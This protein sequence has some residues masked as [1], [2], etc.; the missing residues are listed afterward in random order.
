VKRLL[1][2]SF[3]KDDRERELVSQ[4]L[5]ALYSDVLSSNAIGKGFERLFEIMD[6][7]VKDAPAAKTMAATFLAR[8]V[9]DEVLPPSFVAD[10][11]VCSL[12]GEIVDL[13]RLMLSQHHAGAKLERS[14]GPGDGR[15]VEEMKVTIDQVLQEYLLAKDV[16]EAKRCFAEL[17]CSLFYHEIVKRAVCNAMDSSAEDQASMSLLLKEL[18][19][20][21]LL[22]AQQAEKGFSRL[23]RLLPD[24]V[25]DSPGAVQVVE[26]FT[27]RARAD[28]LLPAS[29]TPPSVVEY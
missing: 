27:E 15:P 18:F 23:Y 22:S 19:A 10:S 13:A 26:G 25:L 20:C 8:A 1:N 17:K 9:T 12:G 21:E 29:Y 3:D 11:V 14:W 4:L 24:L 6:E 5:S 7:V 2:S 28:G 16:A